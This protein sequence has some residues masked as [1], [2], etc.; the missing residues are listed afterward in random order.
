[1]SLIKS[2]T[3]KQFYTRAQDEQIV[4]LKEEGKSTKEIST[5]VGHSEASILYRIQR[6]LSKVDSFD[7]ISYKA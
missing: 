6:K 7:E 1:M 2:K 3:S 5:A 4:A